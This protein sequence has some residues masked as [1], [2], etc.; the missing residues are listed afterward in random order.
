MDF[1]LRDEEQIS[2]KDWEMRSKLY[3]EFLALPEEFVSKMRHLQPQ[4]GCF[5]NCGFCSK[6]SVCKSEYWDIESLRNIIAALKYTALEYTDDEVLLAYGRQ[7]H[8]VGVIF[9]YLNNDIASYPHLD[10]FIDLCYKEL[11]VRTRISTVGYSRKNKQLNDMHKRIVN[12]DLL[13]SLAGVRLSISQYGRVW[14]EQD[15]ASKVEYIKDISNFL[16]LYKKYYDQYG[17]GSRRMCVELRYNPLVETKDVFVFNYDNKMFIVTGNYVFIH[18]GIDKLNVSYIDNAYEHAISL[19]EN[20]LLFKEYNLPFDV[21]SKE[22]F[23]KYYDNNPLEYVR[24]AK[25]YEMKNREGIYYAINPH[26]EETGNYGINIFPITDKRKTSGYLITE[27]FFLNALCEFK[28]KYNLT[29]RGEVKKASWED[30]NEVMRLLTKISDDYKVCGKIEKSRY[31]VEHV[32]PLIE[33]YVK[34]LRKASYN[35]VCF[36]DSKFTIDTGTICNLGR[37][38]SLFKGLT[39]LI[40]EP[41]TPTHERNYGRYCSTMKQENYAWMLGC[42]FNNSLTIQKLELFNTASVE[43]QVSFSKKLNIPGINTLITEKDKYLFPGAK[44]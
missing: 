28:K 12:S 16:K 43:G 20:Y 6:F 22:D 38:L 27:R 15:K 35:P 34:A 2:E 39:K 40:N 42:D 44:E 13:H 21:T 11:G 33:V 37:A 5:N 19:T 30:V 10:D 32:I 7:E 17:S 26:I 29:L 25:V 24:D 9:P 36:F 18:D 8:R 1:L 14:E 31:I 41:L 3:N 23:I 4:I